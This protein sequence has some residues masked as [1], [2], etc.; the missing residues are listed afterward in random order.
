MRFS[1]D[2]IFGASLKCFEFGDISIG[3]SHTTDPTVLHIALPHVVASVNLGVGWIFVGK[4]G[5][6]L[7]LA[8]I[9]FE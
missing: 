1:F 8:V 5:G 6:I 9:F 4:E 7:F 2:S 3:D